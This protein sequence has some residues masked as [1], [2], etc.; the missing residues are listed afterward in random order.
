MQNNI[1]INIWTA[2]HKR[3]AAWPISFYFRPPTYQSPSRVY[4]VDLEEKSLR[5]MFPVI[6]QP[7]ESYSFAVTQKVKLHSTSADSPRAESSLP[8][9]VSWGGVVS[10]TGTSVHDWLAVTFRHSVSVRLLAHELGAHTR[11][12][13]GHHVTTRA[14]TRTHG[15]TKHLQGK[16]REASSQSESHQSQSQSENWTST[17]SRNLKFSIERLTILF[18]DTQTHKMKLLMASFSV[19]QQIWCVTSTN[20]KD[21]QAILM[22]IQIKKINVIR[23]DWHQLIWILTLFHRS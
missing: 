2:E 10:S 17:W 14:L 19:S 1:I 21:S 6:S 4:S 3:R 11:A 7:D 5:V 20:S 16:Q 15:C 8:S 23:H 9:T 22:M 12:A 18:Y 13:T